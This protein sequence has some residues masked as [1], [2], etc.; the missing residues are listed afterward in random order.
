MSHNKP[1]Y[2]EKLWKN[3]LTG[4]CIFTL[5]RLSGLAS[6]S[7]TSIVSIPEST[8]IW[9]WLKNSKNEDSNNV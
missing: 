8:S 6:Y 3:F 4:S 9:D 1:L 5:L 7:S 2:T